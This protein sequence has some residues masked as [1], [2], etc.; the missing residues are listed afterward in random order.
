[1]NY[2]YLV[3]T[4]PA[5][6]LQEKAPFSTSGFIE[7]CRPWLAEKDMD[8]IISAQLK[9]P[10]SGVHTCDTLIKWVDFERNLRN[11][12]VRIRAR[13]LK[14][15]ENHYLRY[16]N[17]PEQYTL[18]RA[19]EIAQEDSPYDAEK[20]LIKLRWDFLDNFETIHHFDINYLVIYYLK[21]QLAER[22]SKFDKQTGSEYFKSKYGGFE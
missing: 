11:V 9:E 7:R 13:N 8:T 15:E 5:L 4:L 10:F 18:T 2:F 22:L 6:E 21:L 1:M 19:E 14:L 16:P 17:D 12:L 20:E 3:S